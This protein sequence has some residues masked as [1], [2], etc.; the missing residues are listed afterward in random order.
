MSETLL[1]AREVAKHFG[2]ARRLLGRRAPLVK[3]VDGVTLELRAG[4]TLGLV[5]ESG[6]G[7]T[8]LGRVLAGLTEPTAGSVEWRGRE[9]AGLDSSAWQEFR[10][11]VQ[12]VFQDPTSSL[13]PRRRVRRIIGAPLEVLLDMGRD[14]REARTAELL[15]LVGLREEFIDRYPHEFSGGQG[16]RIVIAR[17]LAAEP[18]VLILDEP[19][20]ALDVSIQAQI[21]ELL[22]E[23]QGRLGLTYL[24]IS[25]DL[26]VV[27]QL[28]HEVVVMRDGVIVERGERAALFDS[29][30]HPYT[31]ELLEAVPVPG[32]R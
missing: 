26:A 27:E 20:S 1:V 16:Q 11:R 22:R 24:F 3:A 32:R 28:C 7:K 18:D 12:Y 14:E 21:L 4:G 19:T 8:T 5:G 31:R 29:P 2:G 25:H 30:E 10:K 13:N 17:A 23:L 9:I 6:S 15:D